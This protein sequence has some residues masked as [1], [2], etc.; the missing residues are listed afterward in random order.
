MKHISLKTFVNVK[1]ILLF[2]LSILILVVVFSL[3]NK[4]QATADTLLADKVLHAQDLTDLR[5]QTWLGEEQIII[6]P[7]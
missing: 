7:P 3:T 1:T 4:N 2:S 5:I 6:R